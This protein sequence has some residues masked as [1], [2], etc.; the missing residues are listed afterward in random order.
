MNILG[1]DYNVIDVYDQSITIP[2]SY[3]VNDNKTGKGHGEAKLYMGSK[4]AMRNFYAG[5][6]HTEGFVAK[7]FV[8]KRDIISLL[9]TIK[10][11]YQYPSIKYRGMEGKKNML[12]L[13]K[14]RLKE[15]EALN[16]IILFEIK[17]QKQIKGLRGYVNSTKRKSEGYDLIRAMALPFVS[18]ISVMKLKRS[19]D[20]E[21]LFY[22]RPFADFTQMAS[23]QFAAQN[24]GKGKQQ[25][26]SRNR[27]SQV[28]YREELYNEFKHCP[29]THI[30]EFKLLI[31]SHIK[32]HAVST[33]KEQADPNNGLMLSPLY[34]KLF[35]KGY[36]SFKENGEL[37][38]SDWLSPQNRSRISFEYSPEDLFLNEQRKEYLEYHRVNVFK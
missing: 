30:D 37:L 26:S 33:K 29:F 14:K 8:L 13:W 27:K 32:P 17:D 7:C 4:D 24:Y 23:M 5:N 22:W 20:G 3:V 31:A 11:E 35:D 18:Y 1:T 12:H 21:L 6:P 19:E 15:A 25:E 2:D 28:K 10:H 36:I 9:R 38:I 34:D 16:D